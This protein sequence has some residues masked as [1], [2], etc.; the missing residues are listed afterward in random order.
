M[1]TPEFRA[2]IQRLEKERELAAK[3]ELSLAD[4]ATV[5]ADHPYAVALTT[6]ATCNERLQAAYRAGEWLAKQTSLYKPFSGPQQPQ[7]ASID[8]SLMEDFVYTEDIFSF[9]ETSHV[10]RK[11]ARVCYASVQRTFV[12]KVKAGIW[13]VINIKH[14]PHSPTLVKAGFVPSTVGSE[15]HPNGRTV[16]ER[17]KILSLST[18]LDLIK[19]PATRVRI[20]L[21]DQVTGKQA[22]ILVDLAMV[23]V[24]LFVTN[25]DSPCTLCH[26]SPLWRPYTARNQVF[27]V[28]TLVTGDEDT[29]KIRIFTTSVRAWLAGPELQWL[30]TFLIDVA[31]FRLPDVAHPPLPGAPCDASDKLSGFQTQMDRLA[32]A[33]EAREAKRVRIDFL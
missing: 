32:G 21:F 19:A 22:C 31:L 30:R 7:P 1:T 8:G 12:Q 16:F 15:E 29:D 11:G 4:D 27:L 28:Q 10:T 20:C 14:S 24:R 2:T 17:M 9:P 5:V 3:L 26:D 13:V 25:A 6:E 33:L 23:D 18:E